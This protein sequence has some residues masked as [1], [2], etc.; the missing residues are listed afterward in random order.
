M[1]D[2]QLAQ[3]ATLLW[4]EYGQADELLKMAKEET[5][6]RTDPD[7]ELGH[8]ER[9]VNAE[10]KKEEAWQLYCD[11]KGEFRSQ[12]MRSVELE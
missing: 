4:H 10:K 3:I 8:N 12:I 7:W 2:F 5:Y 11:F 1:T 9:I 6:D